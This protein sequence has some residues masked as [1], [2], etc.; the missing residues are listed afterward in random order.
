MA[1]NKLTVCYEEDFNLWT[2]QTVELLRARR[3]EELDIDNLIAELESMSKRDKREIL[4]KLKLILM[5][6]LKWNYQP[7]QQSSSSE[8]TIRNNREEIAQILQDSPSLKSY[9]ETVLAQAYASDRKNAASETGLPIETFP[10]S[11]PFAIAEI[12]NEDF[13]PAE[14]V[15]NS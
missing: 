15:N 12:L 13:L 7:S 1:A 6:L 8:T 4:S 14:I 3:F 10:E 5:H 11:C 2:E 9:P